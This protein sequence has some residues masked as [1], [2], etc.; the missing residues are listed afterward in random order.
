MSGHKKSS[1]VW[2]FLAYLPETSKSRCEV[3]KCGLLICEKYLTNL[4]K[5]LK[6]KHQKAFKALKELKAAYESKMRLHEVQVQQMCLTQKS[7][8]IF[9]SMLKLYTKSSMEYTSKM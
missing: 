7:I 1:L 2:D 5:H 6:T 4:K 8:E 3:D 9:I